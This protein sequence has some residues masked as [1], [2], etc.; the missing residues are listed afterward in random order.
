VGEKFGESFSIARTSLSLWQ[1]FDQEVHGLRRLVHDHARTR[2]RVVCGGNA[3]S[4]AAG[5]DGVYP[6][7]QGPLRAFADRIRDYC[8]AR[9][10][11]CQS[12]SF[13]FIAHA[14]YVWNFA[15]QLE[16]V[17]FVAGKVRA[18][19]LSCGSGVRICLFDRRSRGTAS[20]GVPGRRRNPAAVAMSA[21]RPRRE[22]RSRSP[23]APG[24]SI[25]PGA[26]G[27]TPVSAARGP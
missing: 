18:W 10:P 19:G 25:P 12:G 11:I 13:N 20:L 5:A 22:P 26:P 15:A 2:P 7:R 23:G 9:D 27:G 24:E 17:N 21:R 3:G 14:G 16:A 8:G 1:R 4:P 6:R